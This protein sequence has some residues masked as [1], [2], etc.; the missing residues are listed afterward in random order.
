MNCWILSNC[1]VDPT[2]CAVSEHRSKPVDAVTLVTTTVT[3]ADED[4]EESSDLSGDWSSFDEE[5]NGDERALLVLERT[6]QDAGH[7]PSPSDYLDNDLWTTSLISDHD[8]VC[9]SRTLLT[10]A[11]ERSHVATST[12]IGY[13]VSRCASRDRPPVDTCLPITTGRDGVEIARSTPRSRPSSDSK[14]LNSNVY[15]SDSEPPTCARKQR[16]RRKRKR[17]THR[18]SVG[19]TST[20]QRVTHHLSFNQGSH[21]LPSL[22]LHSPQWP[23]RSD[24]F[25]HQPASKSGQRPVSSRVVGRVMNI[26]RR[27]D[28][29]S[30]ATVRDFSTPLFAAGRSAVVEDADTTAIRRRCLEDHCYFNRKQADRIGIRADAQLRRQA[31]CSTPVRSVIKYQTSTQFFTAL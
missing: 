28:D 17:Q 26:R 1:F 16:Q 29:D 10:T 5:L 31:A 19:F 18:S 7:S 30:I 27:C 8:D 14:V 2:L 4:A 20:K 22:L 12:D 13:H 11:Q 23:S 9:G 21:I 6:G 3:A 25:P 15:E 24:R